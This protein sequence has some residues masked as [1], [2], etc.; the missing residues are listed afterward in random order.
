MAD[1]RDDDRPWE[2][3]GA[4]R[5][6]CE[7]HRAGLIVALAVLGLLLGLLSLA[8]FPLAFMGLPLSVV[9]LLMARRDLGLTGKGQMHPTGREG[10][11]WAWRYFLASFARSPRAAKVLFW[12]G[13]VTAIAIEQFDHLLGQRPGALDGASCVYF[14]GTR[15]P[16]AISDR[17]ILAGY[18]G[19]Q[20]G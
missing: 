11:A 4:V 15:S 19:A 18:R 12:I 8:A 14:L 20:R 17:D 3:P 1:D 7:P 6:D 2:R 5:R 9:A 13:R 10:L 16:R